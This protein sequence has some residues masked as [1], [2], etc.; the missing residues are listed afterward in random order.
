MYF[1]MSVFIMYT[2]A[3]PEDIRLLPLLLPALVSETGS[4][5]E[6]AVW[7]GELIASTCLHLTAL[8]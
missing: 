1:I 2:Y 8:G 3:E 5:P 4:E 6:E 7:P